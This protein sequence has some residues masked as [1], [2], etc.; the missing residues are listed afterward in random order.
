MNEIKDN[1]KLKEVDE[2]TLRA[3]RS[4]KGRQVRNKV[5]TQVAKH[6]TSGITCKNPVFQGPNK[7]K[8]EQG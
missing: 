7:D 2:E 3:L 1:F 4:K 8:S 5:V 6:Q